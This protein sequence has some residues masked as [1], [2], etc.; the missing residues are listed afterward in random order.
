M[1]KVSTPQNFSKM[2]EMVQAKIKRPSG[3]CSATI[4]DECESIEREKKKGYG[5]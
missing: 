1:T 5:T 4:K 2:S 3:N